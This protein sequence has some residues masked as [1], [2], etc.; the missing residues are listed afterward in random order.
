[1]LFRILPSRSLLVAAVLALP[2][3]GTGCGRKACFT[4][5]TQEGA[6]PAQSEA[7]VFFSNPRCP[8]RITS[9]ESAPTSEHDGELCCYEVIADEKATEGECPGGF[10]G[11]NTGSFDESSA[12]AVSTVGQGGFGAGPVEPPPCA[13]CAQALDGVFMTL[14]CDGVTTDLINTLFAC[15]CKGACSTSCQNDLCVSESAGPECIACLQEPSQ[16]CGDEFKACLNDI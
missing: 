5:T 16:G 4:W 10:G 9:I 13:H 3:V 12:F 8:G 2:F 1:M 11:A 14:P 6:C 15:A 7:L